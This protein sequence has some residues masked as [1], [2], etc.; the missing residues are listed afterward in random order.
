[1][2]DPSIQSSS[3]ATSEVSGRCE[4]VNEST[5]HHPAPEPH[6]KLQHPVFLMTVKKASS[7]PAALCRRARVCEARVSPRYHPR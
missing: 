1:M 4:K 6:L 7:L 3:S 5:L 2:W